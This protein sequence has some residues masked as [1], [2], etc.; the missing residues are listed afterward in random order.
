MLN[1]I[2][3]AMDRMGS[4]NHT[5]PRVMQVTN[6]INSTAREMVRVIQMD[7]V[8]TA[9]VLRVANSAYFAMQ[10]PVTNLRRATILMGMNTI[11]NLALATAVRNS[12]EIRSDCK[13]SSEDFWRYT[14]GC[15]V[16]SDLLA[17]RAAIS[18]AEAEEAFVIGILHPIG[19]ALLIQ[20][21]P[22]EYNQVIAQAKSQK[23]N[24][25]HQ[26]RKVFSIDNHAIGLNMVGKWK[27]PPNVADGILF[28]NKPHESR[29]RS[30]RVLGIA[31]HHIKINRIGFCGDWIPHPISDEVYESLSLT[32]AGVS[33]LVEDGLAAE[34]AK[35]EDFIKGV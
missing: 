19:R 8:L 17:R 4:L 11:R 15:A 34:L 10:E 9:R 22:V 13:V 1:A 21:F 24:T 23:T 16:L 5:L 35:A 7:P 18:R 6:D 27:L 2:D 3:Q 30:T 31:V 33:A 26:E 25:E 28:Q 29:L 20:H 12:F 32:R 14:V